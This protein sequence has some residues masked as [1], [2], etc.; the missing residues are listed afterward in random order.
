MFLHCVSPKYI[1]EWFVVTVTLG[2]RIW[3][4]LQFGKGLRWE[5]WRFADR[6][7]ILSTF[8]DF[9][10]IM[11][12]PTTMLQECLQT[13]GYF[14]LW[15]LVG[16]S[17]LKLSINILQLRPLVI[18]LLVRGGHIHNKLPALQFKSL[19]YAGKDDLGKMASRTASFTAGFFHANSL[20]CP[21][22][23]QFSTN[24]SSSSSGS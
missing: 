20:S 14:S 11:P 17:K 3:E 1:L 23:L 24:F 13:F 5:L 7:V 2:H 16:M 8:L 9:K 21:R 10:E 22:L 12:L 19:R 4:M 15:Y 6:A 18:N